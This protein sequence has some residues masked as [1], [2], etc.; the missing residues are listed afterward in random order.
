MGR[1]RKE[2]LEETHITKSETLNK[3]QH[4]RKEYS[5]WN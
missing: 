2:K 3:K 5:Y 4:A 1:I